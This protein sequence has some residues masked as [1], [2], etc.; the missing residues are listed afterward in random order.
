MRRIAILILFS[1]FSASAQSPTAGSEGGPSTPMNWSMG[2]FTGPLLPSRIHNVDEQIPFWGLKLAHDSIFGR[3][4]YDA[5]FANAKGISMNLF[6]ISL[7]NDWNVANAF[8][9]HSLLG[10]DVIRY[11]P[12]PEDDETENP[13]STTGGW[14]IGAGSEYDITKKVSFRTDFR[15]G[16]GPGRQLTLN[17]GFMYKFL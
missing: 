2:A 7:K 16:F 3:I 9:V 11:K 14:H 17:L 1:A 8:T 15:L 13:W 10:F 4:E 5:D 6:Y 12:R